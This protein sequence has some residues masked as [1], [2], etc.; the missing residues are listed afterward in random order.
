MSNS[1]QSNQ[2]TNPQQRPLDDITVISLEHAIAA[3][4]CTR[5]LAD[6]GARVIKIERPNVGDFARGYDERVNGLASHFVWVNRGKESLAL[7]LKSEQAQPVLNK[8]LEKADVLVQNLAPGASARL[9]L[10]YEELH[11]KYPQLIVC[12]ISGYGVGG[13]YEQ[14]K[15]YDLLIQSESGLL[16][17]TGTP[18]EMA[19]VGISIADICAGMYGYSSILAALKLRDKTG[20]GSHIDV[21]ML[22]SLV[23]WMGFPLYYTYENAPAPTRNGASHATIYPYGSFATSNGSVMFGLQNEREWQAFCEQVLQQPEL[24]DDERFSKN[25]LRVENRDTLKGIIES[26]FAELTKSQVTE[27]L[28]T[29]K[30]ANAHV[31]EMQDVWS[32]PQLKARD[33]W[34]TINSSIGEL[35]AMLPPAVNNQ[36]EYRMGDVPALGEHTDAILAELGLGKD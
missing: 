12:D 14:K 27:R 36:F 20:E 32:H 35:P 9:G 31:N 8:L 1:A 24:A 19:K 28:D 6:L 30:I 10:G 26:C 25:S 15:A 3:P 7:D 34:R 21:S 18:D 29:A 17:V 16:S 11:E 2:Q 13:P 22:E 4:F 33:R 5:Q 23:E